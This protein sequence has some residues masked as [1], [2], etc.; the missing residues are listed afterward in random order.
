MRNNDQIEG[1]INDG[2]SVSGLVLNPRTKHLL[3][4]Q[5]AVDPRRQKK[6]N[7]Y[8]DDRKDLRKWIKELLPS[9]A[10]GAFD[11]EDTEV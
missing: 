6:I 3:K 8:L 11:L 2:E 4:K 5:A 10:E 7:K 9:D 1:K